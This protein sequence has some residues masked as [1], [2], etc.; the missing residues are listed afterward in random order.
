[1]IKIIGENLRGT[2]NSKKKNKEIRKK[3]IKNYK[4][5]KKKKL[6]KKSQK[7]GNE[8]RKMKTKWAI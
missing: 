4:R 5:G 2:G 7:L 8:Q 6:S 3:S 1:M